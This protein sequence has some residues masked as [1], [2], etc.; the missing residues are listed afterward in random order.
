VALG[1]A[2]VFRGRTNLVRV[3]FAHLGHPLLGYRLYGAQRG[4]NLRRYALHS[5]R[6]ELALPSGGGRL[7]I[8]AP[9]P[10]DF[11]RALAEDCG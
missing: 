10:S 4:T 9:V 5:A 7:V 6:L 2:S 1:R 8:E 3:N 11:A